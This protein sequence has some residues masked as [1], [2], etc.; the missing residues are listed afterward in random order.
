MRFDKI[1]AI[2]GPNVYTHK[3]V[4]IGRL[5]LEELTE[6]SSTEI[7][8][9]T[10]RLL[11]QLPGLPEHRCSRGRPGGFVERLREGTY[12]AHIVEHVA[13][14]LTEHAGIPSY[15]GRARY[16]GEEGCYNVVIEYKAEQGARFLLDVAVELVS[17]LVKGDPYPLED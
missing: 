12:F 10:D 3:P 9:F 2:S 1:R 11:A 14:E 7:P 8:G 17:A 4:L 13:L 6:K 16:A 15:F 5:F